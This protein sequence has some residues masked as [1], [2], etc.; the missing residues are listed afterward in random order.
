MIVV[1]YQHV[2]CFLRHA[3]A[4]GAYPCFVNV[5]ATA[6]V[7][8]GKKIVGAQPIMP[9]GGPVGA[10]GEPAWKF[11]LMEK[12]RKQQKAA[13]G[14]CNWW[15]VGGGQRAQCLAPYSTPRPR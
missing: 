2:A 12:K 5:T 6:T 9:M 8:G 13:G 14:V 4:T 3:I 1:A 7:I 10:G 11:A 15:G